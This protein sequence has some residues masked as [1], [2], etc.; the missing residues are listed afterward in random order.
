MVYRIFDLELPDPDPN[1]PWRA[2][3]ERLRSGSTVILPCSATRFIS[4]MQTRR[5][6]LTEYHQKLDAFARRQKVS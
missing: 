1:H 6:K 5:A 2:E 3:L 4:P